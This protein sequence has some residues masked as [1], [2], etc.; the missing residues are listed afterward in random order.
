MDKETE[1]NY[2]RLCV[3]EI[4]YRF[5]WGDGEWTNYDFEK[6]S[7]EIQYDT[8]VNLSVT[9]LKRLWGKLKYDSMPTATTL[10]T[11]AR[12]AGY[13]DWRHF[14]RVNTTAEEQGVRERDTSI[15]DKVPL[16]EK[17]EGNKRFWLFSFVILLPVIYFF[18]FD[19]HRVVHSEDF[20]F[21]SNKIM[22]TGVPN[23]VIFHYQASTAKDTVFISQSWDVSRKKAVPANQHEYSSIYYTPGYFR[24]KLLVGDQIV[25]EHDLM[26]ASD[27]WLALVENK[28]GAPVYFGKQKGDSIIVNQTLF[29]QY[30]INMQPVLPALRIYNVKDMPGLNTGNF[31]FETSVKS[32][33]HDGAA[34]CQHLDIMVLCKN[35]VINIPLSARGCVGD[36]ILYAG[37]T[38]IKSTDADLSGFGCDLS[39]WV[40]VKVTAAHNKIQFFINGKPAYTLQ[41]THPPAD[42]VGVEYRFNGPGAVKDTKFTHDTTAIQL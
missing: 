30:N 42:I 41:T 16:P 17:A 12:Y 19:K 25:K 38:R 34:A 15:A 9:T 20:Q 27:G 7:S 3:T 18:S 36:L 21:S 5:N 2:I 6:L 23:S 24:A 40:P 37:G 14:K 29:A 22:S 35:D 33:Y 11:L 39:Q 28:E 8:G 13:E 32:D 4:E 1:L 31:T 10:N 26:I